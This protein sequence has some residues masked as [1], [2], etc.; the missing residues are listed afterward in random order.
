MKQTPPTLKMIAAAAGVHASTASRALDPARRHLIA[1]ALALHIED[2]ARALGYRRNVGAAALRTGRSQLVGVILPDVANPVFG[3]ILQGV[4]EALAEEGYAAIIANAGGMAEKAL[5]AAEHLL[6]RRVEALV[7]ASAELDD[8]VV[9]LCLEAG[10]PLVLVNRAEARL[11]THTVVADDRRGMRFAVEN[12][13]AL[14]HRQIGHIAGPQGVSTGLWRKDG[15]VEAMRQS[16]LPEGPVIIADSYSRASGAA[17]TRMLLNAHKVTALAVANDLLALG[18]Y[19][20]LQDIGLRCP[21]DISIIGYND[22]P[23][24]D[25]VEPALS[26]VRINPEALGH[27]AGKLVLQAIRDRSLPPRFEISDPTLVVRRS[28]APPRP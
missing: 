27:K 23:L 10:I 9:S 26:T 1:E 21:D 20:A 28:M 16:G 12:L 13:V 18:A 19:A 4:E 7:S 8:P 5:S 3:P 25:L 6:A 2:T 14:G 15:F 22:M 17:A 24:V 11:R